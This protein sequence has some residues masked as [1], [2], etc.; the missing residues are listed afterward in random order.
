MASVEHKTA[1]EIATVYGVSVRTLRFFEEKGL[2]QPLRSGEARY[3]TANDCIRLE[4]ILKGRR[5][6]FSLAEIA[7]LIDYAS[8]SR[9]Q[10]IGKC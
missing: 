4:L 2:L 5:L 8:A 6:G 7:Q 10:D 1:N 9:K 3:Y